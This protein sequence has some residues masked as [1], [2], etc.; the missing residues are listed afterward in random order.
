MT[1]I[2]WNRR[3]RTIFTVTR[4]TVEHSQ[5]SPQNSNI[6]SS[7]YW[8]C[9]DRSKYRFTIVSGLRIQNQDLSYAE[10]LRSI[11][12]KPAMNKTYVAEA[13]RTHYFQY[14]NVCRVNLSATYTFCT[15]V[16]H[17]VCTSIIQNTQQNNIAHL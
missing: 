1:K 2:S 8:I 12:N 3:T 14:V 16:F 17:T 7:Q 11:V 5:L 4:L 15:F 10:Y 13:R 6:S 9:F